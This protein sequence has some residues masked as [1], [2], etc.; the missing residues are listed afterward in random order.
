[1]FQ[2]H[3]FISLKDKSHHERNYIKFYRHRIKERHKTGGIQQKA[4]S[5]D[6]ILRCNVSAFLALEVLEATGML[7]FLLNF[8]SFMQVMWIIDPEVG[9]K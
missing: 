8:K 9:N 5:S 2:E 3:K 7:I 4:T 6:G 1:M